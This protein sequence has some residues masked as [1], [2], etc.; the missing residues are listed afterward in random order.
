MSIEDIDFNKL[1]KEQKKKTSFKAKNCEAWNKKAYKMNKSIH[2]SVYNKE[3]LDLIDLKDCESLLD[4]GCGVGNLSLVLAKKL[5]KVFSL[6][7][8]SK[9]LEFLN[10]N[11]KALNLNNIET[12]NSSWYD[13]WKDIPKADLVIASRSMEVKDMQVAL[14]KLNNQANRK[15]VLS[16]KVGGSFVS[17]EVLQFIKKTVNK[18]PDYIYIL[19]ILYNM[20]IHAS[21]NFVRSEGR[22]SK[23]SSY[24]DFEQSVVWSLGELNSKELILL[25][26]YYENKVVNKKEKDEFVKWA[27]ISWDKD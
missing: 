4:V 11:A 23:Y 8:S 27:V 24:E 13:D 1:Y 6:D 3:L 15:V 2:N 9:M 17:D 16:Y 26:A 20:G 5:K 14:V 18:K 10:E 19:N 22:N 12:F 21:L 7:F 25:K